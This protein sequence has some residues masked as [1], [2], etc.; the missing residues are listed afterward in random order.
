LSRKDHRDYDAAL[1][2]LRKMEAAIKKPE[3]FQPKDI[4][5]I[6]LV[7]FTALALLPL[8]PKLGR[9]LTVIVLILM[10]VTLW[11]PAWHFA[12]WVGGKAR[13]NRGTCFAAALVSVSTLHVLFGAYIWPPVKRH[14]L[15]AEDRTSFENALKAQKGDDIEIQIACSPNDERTCT[16][17]GQFIRPI[18]D[19]GWKVQAY[20]SRLMLTKPLDGIMIYRRG[21]NRDYSL[22]HYDAGGYF[23]ISEP[24][25]LAMQKAFQ[26]IQIEPSGGTNPDLPENVMMVYFGPEREDEAEPTDLTKTTEWATGKREGP[27]PGKRRTVLCRWFNLRCG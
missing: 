17:A 23:N 20:V 14:L 24:H 25:L 22:Q 26:S 13:W 9:E 27:F 8:A 12:A 11:Y 16:Y 7:A 10:V 6:C 19:S 15:T 18:G 21:G 2:K 4:I 5:A 3:G 1:Q